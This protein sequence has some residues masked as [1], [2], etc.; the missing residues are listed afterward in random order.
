VFE[1]LL[2]NL[3]CLPFQINF[4]QSKY[5]ILIQIW[6]LLKKDRSDLEKD[7]QIANEQSNPF[8]RIYF[9][10]VCLFSVDLSKNLS[11]LIW[12]NSYSE[13]AVMLNRRTL[14]NN[15]ILDRFLEEYHLTIS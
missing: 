10:L 6:F 14:N 9:S 13:I 12:D 4:T 1:Y 7:I 8:R 5:I 15:A 11:Q 2:N 3:C